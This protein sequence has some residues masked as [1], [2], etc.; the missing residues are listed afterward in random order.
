MKKKKL[1]N[2][3]ILISVLLVFI[4]IGF[5]F[6]TPKSTGKYAAVIVDSTEIARYPLSTDFETDIKTD[7][8]N[9]LI[10]EDGAVSVSYADCKNNVCVKTGKI[11][12]VNETIVCLPHNLIIKIISE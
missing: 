8:V 3:I 1:R 7:G 4:I 6:L 12:K 11:S 10:I 5:I 2:D 9:H